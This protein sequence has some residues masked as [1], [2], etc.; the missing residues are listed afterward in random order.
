MPIHQVPRAL[1]VLALAAT[2]PPAQEADRREPAP[3]PAKKV[4]APSRWNDRSTPR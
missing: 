1:F 3:A 4:E 2:A